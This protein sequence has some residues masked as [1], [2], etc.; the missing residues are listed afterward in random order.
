MSDWSLLRCNNVSED[1]TASSSYFAT[2][3]DGAAN[4][5][6]SYVQLVASLP[7]SISGI[8]LSYTGSSVGYVLA[9]IAVGA[10]ASEKDV[11]PNLM[12][13]TGQ[14]ANFS[15]CLFLP[16]SI[17]AGRRISMRGQGTA[18]GETTRVKM[19]FI[20]DTFVGLQSPSRW[21]DWGTNLG[22]SRGTTV[23]SGSANVKGAWAQLT[24][25]ADF[26][27]KWLM[28]A[29]SVGGGARNI[30]LDIGVGAGGSEVVVVPDLYSAMGN[31]GG[32]WGPF[33]MSIVGGKRVS[34]RFAS[35][36]ASDTMPVQ[37]YGGA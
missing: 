15:A 32:V 23:T 21:I 7:Y 35:S 3:T 18:G 16:I 27:T 19:A 17:R 36:T 9:D 10:S 25:A 4:T 13:A 34:A 6:G 14:G 33:P 20:A 11:I 1:D 31:L 29:Y 26:T 5:K 12:L 22:T 28:A 37:V 2:I 24:A 30:A 8:I